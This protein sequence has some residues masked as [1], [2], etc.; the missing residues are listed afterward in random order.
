MIGI[1]LKYKIRD[2]KT[3]FDLGVMLDDTNNAQHYIYSIIII[4]VIL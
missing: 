2:M 4:P 1:K 3:A